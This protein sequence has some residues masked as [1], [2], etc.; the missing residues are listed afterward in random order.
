MEGYGK[1]D[2]LIH[3][4]V[5]TP[6]ELNREQRQ[7]FQKMIDD[8]NFKPNP[9]KSENSC[10]KP[11]AAVAVEKPAKVIG[12]YIIACA[13]MMGITPAALIFNGIYCLTPPYCLFLITVFA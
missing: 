4:N 8:D 12:M 5:W 13:K 9:E 11:L 2:L 1:G 10:T 3:V 6:K 7:F